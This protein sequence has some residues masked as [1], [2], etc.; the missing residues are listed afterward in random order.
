ML[1]LATVSEIE[2]L[3]PFGREFEEPV[4]EGVFRVSQ[5]KFVGADPVHLSLELEKEGRNYRGI[6]F[7]AVEKAG[8]ES[9]VNNGNTVR[10]AYRLKL[11]NFRGRQSLQIFVEYAEPV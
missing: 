1:N 5:S 3:Q 2:K 8:Q 4:F 6:W 9:P 10:C 7:R 11:N